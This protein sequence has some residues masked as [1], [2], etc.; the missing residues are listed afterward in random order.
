MKAEPALADMAM[1]R[2]SRLSVSPVRPQEWAA[3]L[4]MAG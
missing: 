4:A 1:L 3:I 2:Q